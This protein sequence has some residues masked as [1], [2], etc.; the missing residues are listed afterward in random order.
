[1]PAR[2]LSIQIGLP[3]LHRDPDAR[4]AASGIHGDPDK[5]VLGYAAGHYPL[6]RAEVDWPDLGDVYAVAEAVIQVSQP[7]SPCWKIAHRW[8]RP[9]LTERVQATGRAGW[10]HR[11]LQEGAV[12]AGQPFTRLE[13]PYPEWSSGRVAATARNHKWEPDVAGARGALPE[14]SA[15]WRLGLASA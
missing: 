13:R 1:M 12:E 3:V 7:R 15:C 8:R 9:D 4:K 14:L 5:A 10:Y 11:V 6:W 2:L